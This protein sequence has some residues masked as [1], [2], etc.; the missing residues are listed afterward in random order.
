MD[1]I[2]SYEQEIEGL[3]GVMSDYDDMKVSYNTLSTEH[4]DLLMEYH[5]LRSSQ[6]ASE[7]DV[8][9]ESRESSTEQVDSL[10][11]MMGT[12]ESKIASWKFTPARFYIDH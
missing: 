2:Q 10:K 11:S 12:L 7:R 9:D 6:S 3:K 5:D 8:R 1:R 4:G